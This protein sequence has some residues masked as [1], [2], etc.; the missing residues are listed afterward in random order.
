MPFMFGPRPSPPTVLITW[1]NIPAMTT[2]C[3]RLPTGTAQ[4]RLRSRPVCGAAGARWRD[5]ALGIGERDAVVYALQLRHQQ[6]GEYREILRSFKAAERFG[7][8]LDAVGGDAPF[9]SGLYACTEMFVD[10]FLDLYRKGILRRRVYGDARIQTLLNDGAI[11]ESIDERFLAALGAAGFGSPLDA[12]E[13][14]VLQ[15]HGVFRQDCRYANGQIETSEGVSAAARL[16]SATARAQL[17]T[18]C[19]GRRMT[20]GSLLPGG[21]CV[22]SPGFYAAFRELPESGARQ[23]SLGGSISPTRSKAA[24]SG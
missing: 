11:G 9:E 10:G 12:D 13:F 22:G 3:S 2:I 5:P 20:G 21:F 16:D 8:T 1:S 18:L 19:T 24:T 17:L 14:A 15:A 6:N 7:A 4:R 23:F